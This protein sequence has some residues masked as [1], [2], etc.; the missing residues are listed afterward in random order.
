MSAHYLKKN[1]AGQVL[2]LQLMEATGYPRVITGGV[3]LHIKLASGTVL[4]RNMT[5]VEAAK[6]RVQYAWQV[7]DWGGGTP[8]VIGT[9][10]MEY[11]ELPA[12]GGRLTFPNNANDS[13]VIT[14]HIADA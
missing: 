14:D 13:L 9:H 7:G 8:L 2:D 6:G 1:D 11:E 4:S 3:T 10:Q 12:G 5:V